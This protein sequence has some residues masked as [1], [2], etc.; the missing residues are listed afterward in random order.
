MSALDDVLADLVESDRECGYVTVRREPLEDLIAEWLARGDQISLLYTLLARAK[1]ELASALTPRVLTQAGEPSPEAILHELDVAIAQQGT[2]I[3][4]YRHALRK[5]LVAR[6]KQVLHSATADIPQHITEALLKG[7]RE[8][9]EQ[10]ESEHQTVK[11]V[12]AAIDAIVDRLMA[13]ELTEFGQGG[14]ISKR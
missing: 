9:A 1:K 2:T 14:A 12:I 7:Q 5:Q 8:L 11:I 6:V 13:Q 3:V 10:L 4:H